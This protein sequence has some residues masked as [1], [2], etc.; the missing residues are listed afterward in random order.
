[1]MAKKKAKNLPLYDRLKDMD[2][3]EFRE[4]LESHPQSVLKADDDTIS[5]IDERWAMAFPD[6]PI[7]FPLPIRVEPT[8]GTGQPDTGNGA[9]VAGKEPVNIPGLDDPVPDKPTPQVLLSETERRVASL[10]QTAAKDFPASVSVDDVVRKRK[11]MDL[12]KGLARDGYRYKWADINELEASLVKYGGMWEI[13]TGY[14][15][16]RGASSTSGT[17]SCATRGRSSRRQ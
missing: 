12:P 13:V 17:T 3:D 4:Y 11:E 6:D 10:V 5:Y 14:S 9:P 16:T 8:G 15:V 7:S 2:N 1:M